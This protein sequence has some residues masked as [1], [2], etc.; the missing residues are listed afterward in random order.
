VVGPQAR[1]KRSNVGPGSFFH[2]S[3]GGNDFGRP[4]DQF[5]SPLR[6]LV[7]MHVILRAQLGQRILAPDRS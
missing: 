1:P 4:P 7:Y 2:F 3:R 6:Y 5:R